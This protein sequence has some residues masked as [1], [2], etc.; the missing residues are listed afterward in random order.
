[1]FGRLSK[2]AAVGAVA[3]LLGAGSASAL[4]LTMYYPVSVGGPLTKVV[5]GMVADFEKANPDVKVN[6]IYAGNYDDTVITS[7]SIHYTKLYENI[8]YG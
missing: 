6:A 2:A 5:D 4:E 1:M 7:Y 3:T 8:Q